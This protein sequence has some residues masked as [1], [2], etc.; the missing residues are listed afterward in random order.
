MNI[1]GI[2]N[3]IQYFFTTTQISIDEIKKTFGR[4]RFS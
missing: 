2:I 1:T 4:K 3:R